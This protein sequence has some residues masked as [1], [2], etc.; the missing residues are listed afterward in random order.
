MADFDWKLGP[1]VFTSSRAYCTSPPELE[2]LEDPIT[3]LAW[4][5]RH[6]YWW[7]GDMLLMGERFFGDEYFQAVDPSF[8]ADLL[9]RCIA[10]AA[11]FPPEQRN[12]NLSWSHHL[13]VIKLDPRIRVI[14]LK[15]AE[16]EGWT[17][18]DLNKYVQTTWMKREMLDQLEISQAEGSAGSPD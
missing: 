10:V 16:N 15:K 18:K 7:I 17:S 8:S 1:F 5:Q 13:A 3:K 4:I 11:K 6:I 14:A 2:D 12:P 9:Q